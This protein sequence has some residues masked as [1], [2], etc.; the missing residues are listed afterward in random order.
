MDEML[1]ARP[2]PPSEYH[3]MI[4]EDRPSLA[5]SY[6]DLGMQ[7]D[8]SQVA[9]LQRD[10]YNNGSGDRWMV[11]GHGLPEGSPAD[12]AFR[13]HYSGFDERA[14]CDGMTWQAHEE[15]R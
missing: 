4:A 2:P 9:E 11:S 12:T 5:M 7:R 10:Q 14:R 8:R 3:G 1:N 13:S 6:D 15:V